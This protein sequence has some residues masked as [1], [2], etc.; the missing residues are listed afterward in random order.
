VSHGPLVV[1]FKQWFWRPPRAHGEIIVDRTVSFL[2]LFYD[3][4]YVAVISQAA[5]HLAE[6][7]TGRG[8]ADFAVVFTLIWIA[9][10]NGTLYLDLHGRE[11]GRTRSV[12]FVQMA[13]L[14][15]LA[16]FTA[17]AADGSGTAFALVYAGFLALMT[18]LWNSV[19][20][21]D[22]Q[23][24][25][26]FL[27]DTR[28][29]VI[30]MAA[31]VV[32][33]LASALLPTTPRIVLWAAFGIAWI[34][35]IALA[36]RSR[37]SLSQVMPPTESLVERLAL[38]TIIVLGEV[39]VG[40]VNGL[41]TPDRDVEM[42]LTGMIALGIG[43]GFW[44]IYF[45]LIGRRPPRGDGTALT[46]WLLGHLPITLS[47]AATGAAVVSLIGHAD[48]AATPTG[49]ARLLTGALALGLLALVVI[50]RSLADAERLADVYRPLGLATLG[51]AAAALA[52]GWLRPAPWLLALL[53]VGI[54]TVLWLFAVNRFLHA[55]EW[56]EGGNEGEGQSEDEGGEPTAR[57][58][59]LP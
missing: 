58:D 8:F 52:L 30:G 2:E 15:L 32:V 54:L 49:T 18:W 9:W 22:Q 55:D 50:E 25:P 59:A 48:D 56:G 51:G 34:V 43:F 11:D 1:R 6:H 42:T 13:I 12:V 21:Q 36:G 10:V 39:I 24:R 35:G 57:T 53:L 29:Y 37:P 23:S 19:R 45:D 27:A 40:V 33:I 14:A 31:S 46:T 41:S 44:W 20:R 28:I 16:V 47:I 5:H 3:L 17:D 4:V 7:P 38:F 26:E